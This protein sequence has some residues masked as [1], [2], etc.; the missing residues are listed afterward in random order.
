M[1]TSSFWKLRQSAVPNPLPAVLTIYTLHA[2]SEQSLQSVM[3]CSQVFVQVGHV[4]QL[5][6]NGKAVKHCAIVL[7]EELRVVRDVDAKLAVGLAGVEP[8]RNLSKAWHTGRATTIFW[9]RRATVVRCRGV[10]AV[11]WGVCGSD[12]RFSPGGS[13]A[14]VRRISPPRLSCAAFRDRDR[15]AGRSLVNKCNLRT[16]F[17]TC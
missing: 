9:Y 2:G 3:R 6:F 1:N 12:D 15:G 8:R 5:R 7:G 10:N 11:R 13:V 17:R 16:F 14:C 4:L